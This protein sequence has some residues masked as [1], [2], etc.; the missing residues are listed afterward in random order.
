MTGRRGRWS[1]GSRSMWLGAAPLLVSA[2]L[3]MVARQA[4]PVTVARCVSADRPWAWL[5]VHL[6]LLR[7]HP[8]CAAGQYALDASPG[9]TAGLVVMVAA[10]TLLLNLCT[11]LSMVGVWVTLRALLASAAEAVGRLWSRLPAQP[12]LARGVHRAAP[13]P[14][15]SGQSLRAWQ[16]DR[17]PVLRR[18]PPILSA[19]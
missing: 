5:G 18:G 1:A 15:T 9:H 8:D 19:L 16:L 13:L 11:G 12:R 4:P 7:E 2:V 17:S 14:R 3:W 6:A 10:P